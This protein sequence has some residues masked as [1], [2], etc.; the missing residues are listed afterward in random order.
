MEI[1]KP[2]VELPPRRYDRPLN[3]YKEHEAKHNKI[4]RQQEYGTGEIISSISLIK[5]ID[6]SNSFD[7]NKLSYKMVKKEKNIITILSEGH[8][9]ST[10]RAHYKHGRGEMSSE[11]SDEENMRPEE[12]DKAAEVREKHDKIEELVATCA[13]CREETKTEEARLIIRH[14]SQAILKYYEMQAIIDMTTFNRGIELKKEHEDALKTF[15]GLQTNVHQFITHVNGPYQ[16]SRVLKKVLGYIQQTQRAQAR[17]DELRP[18]LQEYLYKT[19]EHIMRSKKELQAEIHA[20]AI[21]YIKVRLVEVQEAHHI[22]KAKREKTREKNEELENAIA[23]I[24]NAQWTLEDQ[25]KEDVIMC[26]DAQGIC[27][28]DGKPTL[29]WADAEYKLNQLSKLC[30]K[31][32]TRNIGARAQ[33]E[34]AVK[35]YED[36]C[37]ELEDLIA[38]YETK[39]A[40]VE[41]EL[42]EIERKDKEKVKLLT[43]LNGEIEAYEE[44]LRLENDANFAAE[45][46]AREKQ[47]AI[48]KEKLQKQKA[49]I[50]AKIKRKDD[51]RRAAYDAQEKTHADRIA[52]IEKRHKNDVSAIRKMNEEKDEG[53]ERQHAKTIKQRDEDRDKR[54]A[55]LMSTRDQ[56]VKDKKKDI[57][58]ELQLLKEDCQAQLAE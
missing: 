32:E 42:E 12:P 25:R 20:D 27:I 10:R 18:L 17:I 31:L 7:A 40:N 53:R 15:K 54:R 29:S 55:Y 30:K 39:I 43:R 46:E 52:L 23:Q 4:R 2:E 26:F 9:D 19:E 14:A 37:D 13:S 50:E 22:L 51:V 16:D 48:L 47:D 57:A 34:Y 56:R 41:N 45:K 58:T 8:N 6:C 5:D 11:E 24:R 21:N 35:V 1:P 44:D 49:K 36:D 28:Y 38:E 3:M 33:Y